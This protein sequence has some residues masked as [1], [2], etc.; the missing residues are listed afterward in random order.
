MHFCIW[1]ICNAFKNI[2]FQRIFNKHLFVSLFFNIHRILNEKSRVSNM[3]K[4]N[5][6]YHVKYVLPAY[7]HY[8]SQT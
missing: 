3:Y 7:R 4:L 6:K 8:R 5:F 1:N 2:L